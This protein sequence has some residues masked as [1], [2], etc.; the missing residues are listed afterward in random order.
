MF[1]VNPT[2]WQILT[3]EDPQYLN[4]AS[5]F[6]VQWQHIAVDMLN[7]K[8]VMVLPKRYLRLSKAERK[9]VSVN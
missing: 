3:P 2:R 5:Q 8:R 9:Q 1:T 4:Y 6:G 7:P